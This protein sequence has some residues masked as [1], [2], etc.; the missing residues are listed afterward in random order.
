[1]NT[2]LMEI[3]DKVAKKYGVDAGYVYGELLG[4]LYEIAEEAAQDLASQYPK[5]KDEPA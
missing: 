1:M 2:L 3:A 5:K 4:H